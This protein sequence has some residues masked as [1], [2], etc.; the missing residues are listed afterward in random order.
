MLAHVGFLAPDRAGEVFDA[1]AASWL[2]KPVAAAPIAALDLSTGTV[3]DEFLDTYWSIVEDGVAG[4]LDAASITE[5]T[6]GLGGLQNEAFQDRLVR[7]SMQYPGVKEIAGRSTP[8]GVRL[9]TLAACQPGSIGRQYHDLIVDDERFDHFLAF[10]RNIIRFQD[11]FREYL[12][13]PIPVSLS[14]NMLSSL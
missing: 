12:D 8:P 13:R 11:S 1:F 7:S 10:V 14:E 5:R 6:A 2:E 4:S 9:P 3:P